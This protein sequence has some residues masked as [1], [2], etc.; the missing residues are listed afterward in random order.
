MAVTRVARPVYVWWLVG[1]SKHSLTSGDE[2]RPLEQHLRL[3]HSIP[4]AQSV[5]L[6]FATRCPQ[7]QSIRRNSR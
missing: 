5:I 4:I 1:C 3:I 2:R 7:S 6:T